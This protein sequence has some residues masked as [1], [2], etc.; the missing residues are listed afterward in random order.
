M[1]NIKVNGEIVHSIE[2]G[3]VAN[4]AVMSSKGAIGEA[5][6][7]P[8]QGEINIVLTM[9]DPS[10]VHLY[11]LQ[12][13]QNPRNLTADDI[14]RLHP[15]PTVQPNAE[16]DALSSDTTTANE[17]LTLALDPN[18]PQ[19]GD[20]GFEP[21]PQVPGEEWGGDMKEPIESTPVDS[22]S[23]EGS[24]FDF[25][26]PEATSETPAPASPGSTTV[27]SPPEGVPGLQPESD[28]AKTV[29]E[30]AQPD[31]DV[32]EPGPATTETTA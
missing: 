7:D 19:E 13:Q 8:E 16:V 21:T 4:L 27:P 32:I 22:T 20:P 26:L 15:Y 3:R 11:D 18:T 10:A 1:F 17:G 9:V 28:E 12:A 14:E 5:G 31:S 2:E 23:N 24:G 25:S 6:I 30:P 29:D